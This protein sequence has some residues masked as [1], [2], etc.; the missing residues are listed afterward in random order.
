MKDE[1]KQTE[2]NRRLRDGYGDQRQMAPHEMMQ[3][4]SQADVIVE[5]PHPLRGGPQIRPQPSRRAR[6]CYRARMNWP[7][8]L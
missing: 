6:W 3:K 1:F 5:E 7:S 8:G 4:V 2:G